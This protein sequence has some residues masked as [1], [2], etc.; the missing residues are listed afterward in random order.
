MTTA[1]ERRETVAFLHRRNH[2]DE[3]QRV[4]AALRDAKSGRAPSESRQLDTR[5]HAL[6]LFRERFELSPAQ[7]RTNLEAERELTQARVDH[8]AGRTVL[9]DAD[10]SERLTTLAIT[11][12]TP[13]T[14]RP[15]ST[16]G[17]GLDM[18]GLA[19]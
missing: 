10:V 17:S 1:K 16:L 6:R 12:P 5:I 15:K 13:T 2:R 3:R 11:P 14:T 8:L 7:L 18:R 9:V 19:V 4:V